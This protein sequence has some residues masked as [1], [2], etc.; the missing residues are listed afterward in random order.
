LVNTCFLSLEG[1]W[2]KIWKN[3]DNFESEDIQIC[4]VCSL[5]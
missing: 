2:N 1:R 3:R 4:S 5:S